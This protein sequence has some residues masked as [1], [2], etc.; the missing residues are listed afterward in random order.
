[1]LALHFSLGARTVS[2]ASLDFFGVSGPRRLRLQH[3]VPK[4][5]NGK[6]QTTKTAVKQRGKPDKKVDDRLRHA[7][8]VS[9]GRS[10]QLHLATVGLTG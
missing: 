5:T 2:G 4:K 1:M 3:S 6:I 7:D 10:S 9:R 8:F